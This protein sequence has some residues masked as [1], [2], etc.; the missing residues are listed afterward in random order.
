[1]VTDPLGIAS[2]FFVLSAGEDVGVDAVA[3]APVGVP[4]VRLGVAE[5]SAL[6]LGGVSPVTLAKAGRLD[7]DEPERIARLFAST[8]TPRLSFWY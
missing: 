5:L 8:T 7:A 3:E 1:M 4:L 2:G 6:L